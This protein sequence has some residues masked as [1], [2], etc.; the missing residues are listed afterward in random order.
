MIRRERTVLRRERRAM[1]VRE[2]IGVQLNRQ[3]HAPRGG[4]EPVNLLGE[5]AMPSQKAS[6]A[7]A[8]FSQQARAF[9][10]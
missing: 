10:P 1:K 9:V 7:S 6:T 3:S 4:E 2:L 5:K 8:R